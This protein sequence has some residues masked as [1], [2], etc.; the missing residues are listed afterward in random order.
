MITS[1]VIHLCPSLFLSRKTS[2]TTLD[3]TRPQLIARAVKKYCLEKVVRNHPELLATVYTR[4]I[5]GSNG[6]K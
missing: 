5:E 4:I 6:E 3:I 2:N 1:P